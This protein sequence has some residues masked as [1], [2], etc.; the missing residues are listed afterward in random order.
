MHRFAPPLILVLLV[1]VAVAC[2]SQAP[3]QADQITSPRVLVVENFLADIVQNIAGE[4]LTVQSLIPSGVDPHSYQPSPQDVARI[5]ESDLLILNK[6]GMEEALEN[7]LLNAGGDF[8]LV[9]AAAGL[10]DRT[11]KEGHHEHDEDHLYEDEN[12]HHENNH[13]EDEQEHPE[14]E[15]HSH[16]E[17]GEHHGHAH[18]GDPHFWLNPIN[19]ITYVENIRDGL[20]QVDPE[21]RLEYTRN[22]DA[23][24]NELKE[25]D[26]WMV[27]Q[28]EQIPPQRRLLVTN[29]ESLGYFADRYGF[30]VVGAII[31]SVTTGATPSAQDLAALT[32]QIRESGA[33]AVFLETGT[34]PQLAEQ[35]VAET[36]IEIAPGIYSHSTTPGDG[37]APTY[38]EIMRY[39]TRVIVEAL[40]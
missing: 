19:V 8:I 24:I 3:S 15:A 32:R 40:K 14:D 34:N 33:P 30:T 9:E 4:R 35:L 31:P 26:A 17:D 2:T 23:Y 13:H 25:L 10:V 1:L 28:V 20:T 36:G 18:D 11:E 16:E 38:L 5:A 22:A 29:H 12:E 39:N 27:E 21:G 6:L 7:V 37:P